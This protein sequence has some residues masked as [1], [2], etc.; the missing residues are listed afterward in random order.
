LILGGSVDSKNVKNVVDKKDEIDDDDSLEK[1]A[2]D[3]DEKEVESDDDD[4]DVDDDVTTTPSTKNDF[5]VSTLLKSF[6]SSRIRRVYKL[7]CPS[8]ASMVSLSNHC[9]WGRS[10]P[11]PNKGMLL[12][13]LQILDW[14]DDIFWEQTT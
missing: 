6:Y 14:F 1:V 10:L 2:D 5:Q 7:A 12:P 13:Q 9:Y 3:A 4:D 11:L 8:L